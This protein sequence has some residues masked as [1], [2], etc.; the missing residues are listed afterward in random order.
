MKFGPIFALLA[1]TARAATPPTLELELG[2]G[3]RGGIDGIVAFT[4]EGVAGILDDRLAVWDLNGRLLR[5]HEVHPPSDYMHL[6]D[7]AANRVMVTRDEGTAV[8]DAT[9]GAKVWTAPRP[10][11]IG[12]L[13]ANGAHAIVDNRRIHLAKG[14]SQRL[15]DA[16]E[17]DSVIACGLSPRGDIGVVVFEPNSDDTEFAALV[18]QA[19]GATQLELP[20]DLPWDYLARVAVRDDRVALGIGDALLVFDLGTRKLLTRHA[21]RASALAW[22]GDG[23]LWSWSEHPTPTLHRW[24]QNGELAAT[25]P[26][27]GA[28]GR[29]LI[30]TDHGLLLAAPSL[31][32]GAKS[33]AVGVWGLDGALRFRSEGHHGIVADMASHPVAPVLASVSD[34][35]LKLWD[36][37]SGKVS[38]ARLDSQATSVVWSPKGDLIAVATLT[39]V[40]VFAL[41]GLHRRVTLPTECAVERAWFAPSG[42][43]LFAECILDPAPFRGWTT[44]DWKPMDRLPK[45]RRLATI[46]IR[47]PATLAV[48]RTVEL[49]DTRYGH[50][51]AR[52]PDGRWFF[53]SDQFGWAFWKADGSLLSPRQEGEN[54]NAATYNWKA[55]S[56]RVAALGGTEVIV[57]DVSEERAA[58]EFSVGEVYGLEWLADGRLAVGRLDGVIQIWRP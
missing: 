43:T 24:T 2:A 44:A 20:A 37:S 57:V 33:A 40:E 49:E 12:C 54:W 47:N 56:T 15:G 8:L 42:L 22:A 1:G 13:S 36:L 10:A 35:T 25:V 23:N 38:T 53:G 7:S 55:D 45:D 48:Q 39:E 11:T 19:S 4:N 27:A 21:V 58:S 5:T 41:E 32:D 26:V 3:P 50:E 6:L 30:D 29:G 16:V 28:S 52:S 18:F 34:R 46:Q 9:T 14:R 31:P 17:A 51:W